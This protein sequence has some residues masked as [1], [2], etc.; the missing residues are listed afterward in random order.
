MSKRGKEREG[1]TQ[2]IAERTERERERTGKVIHTFIMRGGEREV[3]KRRES[4]KIL[5]VNVKERQVN[6]QEIKMN[7]LN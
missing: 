3:G 4:E 1:E 2:E 5:T 7:S 6:K